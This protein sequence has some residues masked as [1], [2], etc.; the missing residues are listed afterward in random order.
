MVV[1]VLLIACANVSNLLL[2]RSLLRRHEMTMRM[3]L[4]ATRK[5]LMRQLLTEGLILSALAA[6]AG[7][8]VAHWSRNALVLA[9][10]SPAP[11]IIVNF[12]GQIDWRVLSLSAGVCIGATLLFALAPALQAGRVNLTGTLRGESSGIIGGHGRSRLRSVLVS[13]Q[14]AL[15]FVLLAGAG[16]LIQS[17]ER[18][19][20][21][22]PGFSVKDVILSGIDLVSAG[23]NEDRARRFEDQ[24]LERIRLLPGVQSASA[25]RVRPFSYR[26]YSSAPL[27][28]DDY[29][30][31][32]DENPTVDY[33]EVGEDYFATTGI[34]ILSG[35]EFIR[36]DDEKAPRVA[37]VNE[38]MASRYWPGKSA[39][40]QRVKV[41]DQ[42]LQVV[43]VA[44]MANYRTKLE[45]PKPFFY[46]PRRQNFTVQGGL[47]IRTALSPGAMA[48]GLA[49]E[50]RR[51]DPTLAPQDTIPIHEQLDRMT[52]T[53]RL[54]VALLGVFGGV[55]LLLAAVGLYG[56]MSYAVSQS[57]HELG[58]RM[59]L[60]AG[61]RDV[62]RLVL[63]RGFALI[64]AGITLGLTLALALTQ[65]MG[66]LLYQISPRDPLTFCGALLVLATVAFV[67]CLIPA[68]RATRIDPARALRG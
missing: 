47:L 61:T 42:W 31:K 5:R 23:Y 68:L 53:Q 59:A 52:Y 17:V 29:Q 30:P 4:G 8:L 64:G 55:A 37:I 16:L 13:I 20:T 3:A 28:F 40:G 32:A 46:V 10:P 57:F 2:V 48:T 67:A 33:D 11:G 15:S 27:M 36:T 62:L 7:V 19:R 50:V 1:F 22:D 14:L 9:F 34:P 66:K 21:T 45:T 12:P 65:L 39:V 44:R 63:T 49:E 24:L 25:S 56:V 51:L 60:G 6:A 54:A 38:L 18:M 26:N 58:L 35:R 43:G 41:K